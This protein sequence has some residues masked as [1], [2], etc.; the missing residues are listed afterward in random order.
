MKH[1]NLNLDSKLFL[2]GLAEVACFSSFHFIRVFEAHVGETPQQY[3]IRKRMERAAFYLLKG[4]MR[5]IDIALS[6]AYGTPNSFCKV[7]KTHFGISP[8]QFQDT[9]P[10]EQYQKTNHSFQAKIGERKK[11]LPLSI[12]MICILPSIKIICIENRGVMDGSFLSTNLKSFDYFRKQIDRHG[13]K[14]HIKNSVSVY[15][16]RPMGFEDSDVTDLVGAIIERPPELADSF[17]YMVLPRGRYAIFKHY[18]SY[19]FIMQTW[20]QAYWNWLPKSGRC[21][22]DI[23]PIEI[24]LDTPDIPNDLQLKAYLLVP[25]I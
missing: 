24:H 6:V 19:D 2:D 21:L 16:N 8:R 15:P 20:N 25:I 12:P 23:P 22:R 10:I 5:V 18:G 14:D 9:I 3:T 11:S 17:R 13:L 7:F 4:E 1:I